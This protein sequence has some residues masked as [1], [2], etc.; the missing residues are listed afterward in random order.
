MFPDPMVMSSLF[1]PF[2]NCTPS[3]VADHAFGVKSQKAEAFFVFLTIE[4]G[5]A[6]LL[7]THSMNKSFG[8]APLFCL[9]QKFSAEV[10]YFFQ[11]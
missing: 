1:L 4:A 11:F 7:I 10:D 9:F 3:E 6:D 5:G 8:E 2:K